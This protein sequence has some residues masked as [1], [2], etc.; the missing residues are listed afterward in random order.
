MPNREAS[1]SLLGRSFQA[2]IVKVLPP[3]ANNKTYKFQIRIPPLHA[4]LQ[5]DEL[6]FAILERRL[7]V[8]STANVGWF[9]IPREGSTVKVIFDGGDEK[10]IYI[11]GEPFGSNNL[12]SG[13]GQHDYGYQDEHGNILKVNAE[14]GF[15]YSSVN[16]VTITTS[17]GDILVTN[18][19]GSIKLDSAGNCTVI[20]A[21]A[22]NLQAPTVKVEG[23]LV[24]T[25]GTSMQAFTAAGGGNVTGGLA[26]DGSTYAT[27][28]HGGVQTGGSNTTGVVP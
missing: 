11:V 12:V 28:V 14:G 26:I 3:N 27:H 24:V 7:F 20:G 17:S 8:G 13:F 9:S 21:A 22:I 19:G 15:Q 10:G 16:N 1:G 18:H 23:N 6:P 4:G 5:D 2:T 25:G